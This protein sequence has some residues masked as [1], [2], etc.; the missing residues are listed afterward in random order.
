[1]T[2]ARVHLVDPLVSRWHHCIAR[3]VRRAKLLGEK[4]D[5]KE[6][7]EHRLKELAEIVGISVAGCAVLDNHLHLLVRLDPETVKNWSDEEVIRRW[8]RLFPP[9]DKMRRPLEAS[10]DWVKGHLLNAAWIKRARERLASLSWFMKCLK[11]PLAL[12]A[13]H[14]D[15]A[16]GAF[17]E[18]RFKSIAILDEGSLLATCASIDLNPLAAGIA[19]VPEASAHT[20]IKEG[21]EHIQALGR[22][23]SPPPRPSPTGGEGGRAGVSLVAGSA[24]SAGL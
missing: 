5:R 18:G 14:Q 9:R 2:I 10:D 6:W 17:F 13:N 16:S 11:E 22:A 12:L 3:C 7:I 15:Q 1:M 21:V 24:A 20:S 8:A 23:S 4:T 19:S